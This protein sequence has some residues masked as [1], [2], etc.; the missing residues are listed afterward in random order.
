VFQLRRLVLTAVAA[1]VLLL[2][3]SA[4]AGGGTTTV[5]PFP[6]NFTMSWLTCPNL[7]EGTTI[8]G[9]GTGRSVTTT[10]TDRRG[11]TTVFNSSVAPGTATDQDGNR[12]RFLYSNQFR[13]SN[14]TAD[15]D[16][17]SGFMVDL[18]VL[19]GDG[20]ARLR[21]GFLARITTD[22]G[23]LFTFDPIFAFGD[24]INF[25]TGEAVCDPL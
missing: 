15:R 23:D 13:V 21:N 10:K 5:E 16:L 19:K 24:P 1:A 3:G 4:V 12:Y 14:T 20:P 6:A 7:P 25:A 8:E 9:T 17:Y 2:P 11:I 22:L 18:F